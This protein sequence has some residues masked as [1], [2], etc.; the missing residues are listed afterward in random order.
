METGIEKADRER[1]SGTLLPPEEGGIWIESASWALAA[2]LVVYYLIPLLTS[3]VGG[4]DRGTVLLWLG[5]VP[6]HLAGS[7]SALGVLAGRLGWQTT[8]TVFLYHGTV[9]ELRQMVVFVVRQAIW[10]YPAA[11]VLTMM[12][13]IAMRQYG[14]VPAGSPILSLSQQAV[15]APIFWSSVVLSALVVAPLTEEFLFRYVCFNALRPLGTG[16][17]TG[18]TAAFFAGIHRIPEQFAGLFL[19]AFVLQDI[20]RRYTGLLAPLLLHILFNAIAL[21]LFLFAALM[22]IPPF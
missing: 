1:L 20:R 13:E 12:S 21:L 16:I 4:M 14:I 9:A 10:V 5:L 22:G 19:L 11:V 6:L 3:S 15:H 2:S 17:A 7:A 18:L 8:G